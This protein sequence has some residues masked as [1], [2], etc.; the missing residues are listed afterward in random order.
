MGGYLFWEASGCG[1]LLGA[2]G[3][4]VREANGCGRLV[5]AGGWWVWEA[6]GCGRL[7][8]VKNREVSGPGRLVCL[9][10][11]STTRRPTLST[12]H[13]YFRVLIAEQC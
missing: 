3:Y 5:G 6:S 12:P 11:E 10:R 2:G 4:W 9:S 13:I 7:V 1:R 8:G